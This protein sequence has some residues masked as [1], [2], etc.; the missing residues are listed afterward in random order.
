MKNRKLKNFFIRGGKIALVSLLLGSMIACH[1]D[2]EEA[3]R[4]INNE[5]S[6]TYLVV[7]LVVVF[8]VPIIIS[9]IEEVND[10]NNQ[11]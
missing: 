8:G 1:K 9:C 3:G 4:Q 6:F 7:F 10:T 5:D 2:S 11:R